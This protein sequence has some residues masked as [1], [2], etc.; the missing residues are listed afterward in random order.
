MAGWRDT[1]TEAPAEAPKSSWRDTIRGADQPEGQEPPTSLVDRALSAM[2]PAAPMVKNMVMDGAIPKV[3]SAIESVTSAPARSGTMAAME[4]KNPLSAWFSQMGANPDTAPS[5]KDIM[6]KVGITDRPLNDILPKEMFEQDGSSAIPYLP[7][8]MATKALKSLGESSPAG[9]AGGAANLAIDPTN[10]LMLG[11]VSRGV[12]GAAKGIGKAAEGAAE[13][14][15]MVPKPNLEALSAAA[16]RLKVSLTPGMKDGG[17]L[18][19]GME[20]SLSKSPSFWGR[21]VNKNLSEV[22]SKL[23][24]KAFD[25]LS[26]ASQGSALDT[27]QKAQM[28]M[29]QGVS[30]RQAPISMGFDE[31]RDT[32]SHVPLN[33]S[34][35]TA[36]LRNIRNAPP[37]VL[38]GE[39]GDVG[40]VLGMF[41]RAQSVDDIKTILST[42]ND[43]MKTGN[44]L[45]RKALYEVRE[46]LRTMEPRALMQAAITNAKESGG[47]LREGSAKKIASD[48]IQQLKELRGQ[49]AEMMG[50]YRGFA[51]KSGIPMTGGP[52]SLV[53]SIEKVKPENMMSKFF[54]PLNFEGVESTKA[55]FPEAAETLRQ[56]KLKEVLNKIEGDR[57]GPARGLKK[58]VNDLGKSPEFLQ[59]LLGDKL[60]Q[61]Q[62]IGMVHDALPANMNPSNTA[63]ASMWSADALKSHIT[64][65]PRY[66]QY[67]AASSPAMRGGVEQGIR[68]AGSMAEGLGY[69]T[70]QS[71]MMMAPKIPLT[72]QD[73]KAM[74]LSPIE[75]AKRLNDIRRGKPVFQ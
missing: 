63:N 16:E 60:P 70:A 28:Q 67:R 45:D 46:R 30:E 13:M 2:N 36:V 57:F 47:V 51:G 72:E 58:E 43:M 50:D 10:L 52:D 71:M 62:D 9:I 65:I 18:V 42:V 39:R 37:V 25:T 53:S 59:N 69:Q 55:T 11:P 26:D 12:E 48:T 31:V 35:K 54:S 44:P 49:Y 4:G 74:N 41:D 14:M 61:A 19:S 17:G 66:L 32:T 5:G 27:G 73:V 64:D 1:I 29:L 75:A 40:E 7:P 68:S 3:L 23:D 56:G 24:E 8:G 6:K 22:R 21:K 20:D 38:R 15:K 34:G 33:E